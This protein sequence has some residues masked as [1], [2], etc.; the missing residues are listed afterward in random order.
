MG[1]EFNAI[2]FLVNCNH[3]IQDVEVAYKLRN[4]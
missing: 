2:E 1:L 3:L 4:K